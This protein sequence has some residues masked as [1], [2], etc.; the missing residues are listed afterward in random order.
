MT[1][2]RGSPLRQ[3]CGKTKRPVVGRSVLSR[4]LLTVNKA[5]A[6]APLLGIGLED[7]VDVDFV[8]KASVVMDSKSISVPKERLIPSEHDKS[9]EAAIARLR[10]L[11]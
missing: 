5:L 4:V 2:D 1:A 8:A 9:R 7:D 3:G 10:F 11:E 6:S